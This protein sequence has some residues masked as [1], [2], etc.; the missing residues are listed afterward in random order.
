MHTK[1]GGNFSKEP[2]RPGPNNPPTNNAKY[3]TLLD[4]Q[5][6]IIVLNNLLKFN[7]ST[8]SEQEINIIQKEISDLANINILEKINKYNPNFK[9]RFN[10]GKQLGCGIDGVVF[11]L[12]NDLN[13]VIKICIDTDNQIVSNAMIVLSYLADKQPQTYA[14]VLEYGILFKGEEIG[15]YHVMERLNSITDDESKVFRSILSHEDRL[16]KKNYTC[17]QV[18]DMLIG[19]SLGLDFDKI[20]V[21]SFYDEIKK[22]TLIHNDIHERNIMKNNVGDFKLIDFNRM[23]IGNNV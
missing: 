7:S 22:S 18:N 8:F 1:Y 17:Q 19:M 12:E 13:K 6:R 10:I 15:H 3:P 16:A 23:E 9:N 20:K 14:R 5:D 11:E 2:N 4:V 21:L